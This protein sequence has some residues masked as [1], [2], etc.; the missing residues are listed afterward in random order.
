MTAN[1][2]DALLDAFRQIVR[3]EIAAAV[4]SQEKPKL[5]YTTAEAAAILGVP[6]TWLATA[7]REGR[8]P[9]VKIGHYVRFK[10]SDLEKFINSN[11]E[12]NVA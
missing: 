9:C 3:E 11:G 8:I 4:K 2:F 5:T 7:A 10:L 12:K 6:E 1:P